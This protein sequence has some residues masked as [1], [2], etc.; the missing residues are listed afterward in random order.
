MKRRLQSPEA[1]IPSQRQPPTPR[2]KPMDGNGLDFTR[3]TASIE[4]HVLEQSALNLS[5]YSVSQR[6]E[7]SFNPFNSLAVRSPC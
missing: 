1:P 5:Q 6:V 4:T 3:D 7:T 2:L